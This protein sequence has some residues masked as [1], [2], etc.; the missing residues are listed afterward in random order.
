MY[1]LSSHKHPRVRELIED[2]GVELSLPAAL[3]PGFQSHFSPI[4]SAFSNFKSPA[5]P[6]APFLITRAWTYN[7][8][9]KVHRKRSLT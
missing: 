9:Q 1:N 5:A 3:Q 4:E 6:A 7:A 8:L 2:A